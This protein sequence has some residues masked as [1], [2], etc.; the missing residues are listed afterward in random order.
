M[1][2][3]ESPET[4]CAVI[5]TYGDRFEFLSQV[6]GAVLE[7]GVGKALV[8][9]NACEPSS[10]SSLREYAAQDARIVHAQMDKN[11][12]SAGAF[13]IGLE[14]ANE[15]HEYRYLWLLDDD[16]LPE[17]DALVALLDQFHVRNRAIQADRLALASY[18][19]SLGLPEYPTNGFV[20]FHLRSLPSKILSVLRALV[21]QEA[22]DAGP[23]DPVE[24]PCAPWGG[25]L[26]AKELIE[27][28]G[29]PDERFVLYADDTEFTTRI[30][31]KGGRIFLV[32][33]SVVR[34]L[35]PAGRSSA[36]ATPGHVSSMLSSLKNLDDRRAY[37]GYRNSAY[38]SR[39]LAGGM[40]RVLYPLNRSVYL[41]SLAILALVVR[42]WDRFE[43]ILQAVNE[44]EAGTLGRV[45]WLETET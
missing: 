9:D 11:L 13:K 4:V 18:R 1:T 34:D 3:D 10:R 24:I 40:G 41:L 29:L 12:G 26:F 31:R 16:N 15:K 33:G 2:R 20:G 30:V 5:V 8:V 25:L 21:G 23:T 45:E 6:L 42:E 22:A 44:G 39:Q 38:L 14:R 28:M 17:E 32:P 36:D 19:P 35:V 7:A 43:L 37:Y 27:R